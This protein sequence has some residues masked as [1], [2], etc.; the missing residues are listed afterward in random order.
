MIRAMQICDAFLGRYARPLRALYGSHRI[1]PGV[2]GVEMKLRYKSLFQGSVCALIVGWGVL[3]QMWAHAQA[4]A[5]PPQQNQQT[6]PKP[7]AEA[8]PFPEDTTSV[9]V[10]PDANTPATPDATPNAA[11]PAAAIS[12]S[13]ADPVRSPDDPAADDPSSAGESSSSLRDMDKLLPPP[14]EPPTGK[15]G[16][17]TQAPKHQETA[18]ED[19]NVGNYYLSNKNWKAALS[20]FESAVVLDPENPEVYWGL[21]EAQRHLADYANAKVNYQ[22]LMDYDP[23]GKHAKEA[24]KILKDPEMANAPR[25]S[26]AHP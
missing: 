14:D 10:M 22:K 8:N 16:K 20:R 5:D 13:D 4:P 1:T 6:T 17:Q 24:K 11:A 2:A 21:G 25:A 18:A 23:D 3:P 7:P 12:A 19:V 26:A 9:P 15:R